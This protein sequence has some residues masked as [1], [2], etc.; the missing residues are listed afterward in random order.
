MV[1]GSSVGA[2][3]DGSFM[4]V[5]GSHL[6]AE[7]GPGIRRWETTYYRAAADGEILGSFASIP[8]AESLIL[9]AGSVPPVGHA[10]FG[11]THARAWS[12]S[13]VYLSF[14]DEFDVEYVRLHRL[15]KPPR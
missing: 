6:A 8:A 15:R 13:V 7:G 3:P 12:D 1:P 14:P 2:F 10:P 11:R 5:C 9:P 4:I